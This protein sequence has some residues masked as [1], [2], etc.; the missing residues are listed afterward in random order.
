M[1]AQNEQ[2]ISIISTL[3]R[4]PLQYYKLGQSRGSVSLVRQAHESCLFCSSN[5]TSQVRMSGMYYAIIQIY[6]RSCICMHIAT[7]LKKWLKNTYTPLPPRPPIQIQLSPSHVICRGEGFQ[8]I[9]NYNNNSW[10]KQYVNYF[11]M[12][13]K[14]NRICNIAKLLEI[15][16]FLRSLCVLYYTTKFYRYRLSCKNNTRH[17]LPLDNYRI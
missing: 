6:T 15:L 2:F 5:Y 7:R 16:N 1:N 4:N 17:G 3:P 11:T 14:L 9:I 13:V 12:E 8:L 10:M